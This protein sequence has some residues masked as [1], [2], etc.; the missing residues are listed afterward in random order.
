MIFSKEKGRKY[1]RIP[2]SYWMV[3]TLG[4]NEV[5]PKFFSEIAQRVGL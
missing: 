1:A 2:G 4:F 5:K 3:F